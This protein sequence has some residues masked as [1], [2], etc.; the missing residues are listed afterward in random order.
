MLRLERLLKLGVWISSS[1]RR[2]VLHLS[3][4]FAYRGD[5]MRVA[6]RVGAATA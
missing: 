1:V 3:L 6:R 4:A 2:I 5:W